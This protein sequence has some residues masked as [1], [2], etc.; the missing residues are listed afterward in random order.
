MNRISKSEFHKVDLGDFY[1]VN[2]SN[3]AEAV[4]AYAIL[5][6]KGYSSSDKVKTQLK[7]SYF[8]YVYEMRKRYGI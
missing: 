1:F 3:N 4:K 5:K 6:G 7:D 2:C 8:V